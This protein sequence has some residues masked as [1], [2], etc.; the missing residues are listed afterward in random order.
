[1]PGIVVKFPGPGRHARTSAEDSTGYKSGL[2]SC[3]GTPEARSTAITRSGGTS[4]HCETACAV[5]PISL[6]RAAWPPTASMARLRAVLGSLM[7][8]DP[9]IALHL[10]Q[11]SLHCVPKGSLYPIDM[12]LGTRIK[13]ARER[14]SPKVTQRQVAEAFNISDKAVS[15]WECDADRPDIDKALPLARLLKV[16]VDWLLGGEGDPPDPNHPQVAWE[17][18]PSAQQDLLGAVIRTLQKRPPG[19]E[20]A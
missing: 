13:Q 6:A 15:G 19:G 7:I 4:S 9:S 8:S 3:R 2:N 1:M 14:L 5:T 20:A 12:T 17:S 11:V 10:S 16:P 18:L